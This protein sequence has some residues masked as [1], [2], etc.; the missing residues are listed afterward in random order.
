M[1]LLFVVF[2]KIDLFSFSK[3]VDVPKNLRSSD[4]NRL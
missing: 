3:E 2:L 4:D 1:K